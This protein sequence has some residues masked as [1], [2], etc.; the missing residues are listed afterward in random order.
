MSNRFSRAYRFSDVFRQVGLA[1]G[2]IGLCLLPTIAQAHTGVDHGSGFAAGW[3]HPIAG[4][5]HLLTM[6][7]VGLWAAQMGGRARW[8]LPLSFVT[9]MAIG[10]LWGISG[11]PLPGIEVG[12]ILSNLVLGALVL[13]AVRL[14]LGAGLA[15][16]AM[17]ALFH[18]AAHGAEMPPSASAFSYAIG[19]LV[20]TIGLH[21]AGFGLAQWCQTWGRD[22]WV[23]FAGLGVLL[24]GMVGAIAQ[25]FPAL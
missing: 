12:I 4:L 8:A 14:P 25:L 23:Q 15:L 6:V 19:F 21:L 3:H 10:G 13:G 5:D 18:G 16:V 1:V 11:L 22:R 7:A 2:T 17:S 24:G 20:A 9:V